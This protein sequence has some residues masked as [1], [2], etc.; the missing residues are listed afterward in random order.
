MSAP[1]PEILGVDIGGV[2]IDRVND[3]TD[4]SFFGSNYLKTTAVNLALPSLAQLVNRRFFGNVFL[5]SKCGVQTEAKTREWLDHHQFYLRTGIRRE[6]VCFC[7]ERRDKAPLCKELGITHFIDDR[8]EVL[9][10]LDSVPNCFLFQPQDREV[11]KFKHFLPKV[12]RVESWTEVLDR[13]LEK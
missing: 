3:H 11:Q 12:H 1:Q 8:L 2:V 9:G 5:V 13:L 6:N 7:R 10:F 4:T